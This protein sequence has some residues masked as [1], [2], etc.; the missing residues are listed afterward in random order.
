M[1]TLAQVQN[2]T[3][4]KVAG[5]VPTSTVFTNYTNDAV[6]QLIERGNG[7]A[8]GWWGTVRMITG[9]AYDGCFVWPSSVSAV[10]GIEARNGVAKLANSWYSFVDEDYRR[11]RWVCHYHRHPDTIEFDGQTCL[12]RPIASN[13][14]RIAVMAT[15]PQDNNSATI[16]IYGKDSNGNEVFDPTLNTRGI[17]L[18]PGSTNYITTAVLSDVE[19]I[20]KNPT[21]GPLSLYAWSPATGVGSLLA[22]YEGGDVNPQFLFSRVHGRGIYPTSIKSLVKLGF[23]A[24]YSPNDIIAIDSLDAIKAQVQAIKYREAGDYENASACEAD[25]I[26]RLVAQVNSRFPK[27]QFVVGFKPF[28]LREPVDKLSMI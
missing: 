27:E 17:T 1:L 14:T 20:V 3:V 25:A 28:G 23:R 19:A 12:F 22:I 7:D 6:R 2:S 9:T 24:V 11:N 4:A 16:T 21:N 18:T 15:S 10:L 13:P 8:R 5:C 26:K